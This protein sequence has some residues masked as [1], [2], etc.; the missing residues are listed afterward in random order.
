M[1][2]VMSIFPVIATIVAVMFAILLL[3]QWLRRKRIYQFVWFIS[4]ALFALAAGLEMISEFVGWSIGVY[5]IYIVISASLVA[6]MGAGALYLILQKNV[7]STRGL[8]AIDAILLGIMIFFGWTMTLSVITDYSAM[9][10]GAMEYTVAGAGVYAILIVIA[11]LIGRNWEDKR[12]KMLHGHAFLAFVVILTLWM[13]AYAA[14]A[15]VTPENFVAGIAVA[16]QAMAQHVR[17]FSPILTVPGSF[18][19]I[20]AAFF[21]FLKTKFQ[22]NL[23]IALGG[24]AIAIA[25]A[26]ARSG[27]EFGNVLYLGEVVGVLFLYK[28]FVDSDKIIKTREE[29]FKESEVASNPDS[30][31]QEAEE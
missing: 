3:K 5:R 4:L 24:L 8:I 2:T 18:L 16:G 28:G 25:G 13:G 15:V 29:R 23:W 31:T 21:S 14:V 9:V 1:Q 10:F 19:L 20:G 26:I 7:F 30:E 27:T 11:F 6:I 22:F 12:R 17:N